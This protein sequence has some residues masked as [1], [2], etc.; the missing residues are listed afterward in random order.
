MLA[1]LFVDL[2]HFKE[3]NDSFGHDVGDAVLEN[4]KIFYW[5]MVA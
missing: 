2:D 4:K 3:I 1:V 5:Q